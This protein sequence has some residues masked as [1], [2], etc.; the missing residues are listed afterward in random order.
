MDSTLDQSNRRIL[1]SGD[2]RATSG[3]DN[4]IKSINFARSAGQVAPAGASSSLALSVS[5]WRSNFL[6]HKVK[7]FSTLGVGV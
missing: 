4:R 7:K 5:R 3:L 2:E 6:C 1:E